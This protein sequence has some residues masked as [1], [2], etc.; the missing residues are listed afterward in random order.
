MG[1]FEEYGTYLQPKPVL[2]PALRKSR[3]VEQYAYNRPPGL[4]RPEEATARGQ[5]LSASGCATM[6]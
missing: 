1:L 4:S 5:A 6:I 2:T 3:T